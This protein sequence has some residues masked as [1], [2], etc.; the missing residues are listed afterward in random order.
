MFCLCVNNFGVKNFHEE[1]KQHLL[2]ALK[3]KYEIMT[4]H[5]GKFFCDLLLDWNYI[6]GCINVSMP[7]FV[8]ITLKKLNYKPTRY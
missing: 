3:D 5:S 7:N 1:D 8:N 2:N 4:D 6:H